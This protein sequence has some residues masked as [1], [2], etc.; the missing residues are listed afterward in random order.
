MKFL[1]FALAVMCLLSSYAFACEFDESRLEK[2]DGMI[3]K[4]IAPGVS[5][6]IGDGSTARL[7][8]TTTHYLRLEDGV[9]QYLESEPEKLNY[10]VHTD[11]CTLQEIDEG[12][13][14]IMDAYDSGGIELEGVTMGAK[15]KVFVGNIIFKIIRLFS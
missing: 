5:T 11:A 10:I 7:A 13:L 3:V 12:N 1:L 4:D 9:I 14:G 8:L 15:T 6:V 2:L